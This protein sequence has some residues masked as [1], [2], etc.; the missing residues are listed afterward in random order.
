MLTALRII[1]QENFN[2]FRVKLVHE[3]YK[4]CTVFFFSNEKMNLKDIRRTF[5][6]KKHFDC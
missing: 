6:K 4:V 3:V 5:E 1:Y 2:W